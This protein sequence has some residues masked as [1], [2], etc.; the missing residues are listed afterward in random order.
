MGIWFKPKP[1][2]IMPQNATPV[3]PTGPAGRQ[4]FKGLQARPGQASFLGPPLAQAGPGLRAK[5]G[6]GL[7]LSGRR[8]A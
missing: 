1:E 8:P 7:Q 5:A 3:F 6:P 4:A 2:G